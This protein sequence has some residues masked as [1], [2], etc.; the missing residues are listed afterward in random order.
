M[1]IVL[2]SPELA[3]LHSYTGGIGRRFDD[4][5]VAL[6]HRGHDVHVVTRSRDLNPDVVRASHDVKV[7]IVDTGRPRGLVDP[8]VE[9]ARITRVVDGLRP[10]V[11][12]APE[13]RGLLGHPTVRTSAPVITSLATSTRQI[14]S[15]EARASST[16]TRLQPYDRILDSLER[17]QARRSKGVIAISEA[18]LSWSRQLWGPMGVEAVVSNGV[19]REA[20]LDIASR[21]TPTRYGTLQIAFV[22]RVSRWKGANLLIAALP[23]LRSELGDVSLVLAGRVD[24]DLEILLGCLAPKER[25]AIEVLGQI[26]KTAIV[27]LYV[28]SDVAA[29]PSVFE[30]FGNACLEAKMLGLPVVVT[31]GSG[32]DD[33]NKDGVDSLMVPPDDDMR[34]TT[35]L[36]RVL[37]DA[38]LRKRLGDAA[39][40]SSRHLDSGSYAQKIE[41]AMSEILGG[42]DG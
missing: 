28:G 42:H 25:A 9:A 18:I 19:D 22:G 17:R 14:R 2:V 40:L 7:T 11:V 12:L 33:F 21:A 1:R 27:D 8:L 23:H 31:T 30:G 35:A 37:G 20:L 3:S 34:L 38:P 15:L 39:A 5:S 24:P 6:A 13:W 16:P 26:D 10:D 41:R 36:S 4:L 32:F 29:F